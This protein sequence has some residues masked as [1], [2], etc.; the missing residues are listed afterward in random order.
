MAKLKAD[1]NTRR[2]EGTLFEFEA[3]GEI[4]A[5]SL[6]AMDASGKAAAAA[7]GS[8]PVGVAENAAQ[9]GD[10]ITARRVLL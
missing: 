2:R 10:K 1:R 3:S 9:A 8:T 5:G 4:F 6:V 7:A